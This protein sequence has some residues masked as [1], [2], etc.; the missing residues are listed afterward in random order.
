MFKKIFLF[1]LGV[2]LSL[3]SF[4]EFKKSM[5]KTENIGYT[6]F[7][8]GNKLV[9][10]NKIKEAIEE[11]KLALDNNNDINIKKNYEL[12]LKQQENQQQSDQQDQN[13]KDN[14]EQN[15]DNQEQNKNQQQSDQ[16]NGNNNE[17]KNNQSDQ[18]NNENNSENNKQT[19]SE[20]QQQDQQKAD[21]LKSI[22]Q[23]LEGNEKR[24]FKNNERVLNMSED[25]NSENRW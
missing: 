12:A 1:I 24:A 23:R 15:E 10:E 20:Q 16:E 18:N 7:L 11:Y 5:N 4:L 25:K 17:N 8:S 9:E 13:K 3:F 6:K 14:Q 22:M 2:I 19:Q 21:E